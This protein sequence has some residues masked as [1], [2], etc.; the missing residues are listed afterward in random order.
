MLTL[1]NSDTPTHGSW[2]R[3]S[4]QS[5]DDVMITTMITFAILTEELDGK[6]QSKRLGTTQAGDLQSTL[7]K[8][9]VLFRALKQCLFGEAASWSD[10]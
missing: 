6:G 8:Y 7:P 3:V 1:N 4:S 9:Q 5:M 10:I 2:Y